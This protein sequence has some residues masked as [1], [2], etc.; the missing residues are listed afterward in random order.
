MPK[1]ADE[2]NVYRK[3]R[4]KAEAQLRAGTTPTTGQWS[5][6]VDALR[7][8]HRL[9]G[10]PDKAEDALK[11]LH[12]LQVHQV[13]LDLQNDEI[14]ANE[15]ALAED[16]RLYQ[17]LYESA[18]V[19]YLVVDLEGNVIQSN[20]A[21]AELFG[22]DRDILEGQGIDS[23]VHPHARP[24]LFAMLER[25]AQSS[26]RESCRAELIDP[27][28]GSRHVQFLASRPTGQEHIL[29]ACFECE[30]VQ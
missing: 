9:S 17:A 23:L 1:N 26:A 7:L 28:S 10:D 24:Q 27:A 19:G 18:P 14:A 3:L 11:L 6:G 8:L 29:L 16:V 21:G 30:N 4:D 2:S 25:V 13:E 12:E 22:V 15:R 5:M 20:L